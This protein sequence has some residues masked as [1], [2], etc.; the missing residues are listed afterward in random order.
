MLLCVYVCVTVY[1]C[2]CRLGRRRAL[3]MSVSLSGLLGVAVCV[4]NSPVAFLLLRLSQGAMLAGVFLSSY[5]T[6]ESPH[7]P[8]TP[9]TLW[10]SRLEVGIY[11]WTG[12][13]NHIQCHL[14]IIDNV[15]TL[16]T[17]NFYSFKSYLS[18]RH[19]VE[20]MLWFCHSLWRLLASYLT[21]IIKMGRQPEVLSGETN[22]VDTSQDTINSRR[23]PDLA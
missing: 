17:P 12:F 5:I 7:C 23:L 14:I 9:H 16:G 20:G 15:K 21:C 10:T 3:L 22:V 4:S 6:R 13:V 2:V 8:L 1:V 19:S 18:H 11:A